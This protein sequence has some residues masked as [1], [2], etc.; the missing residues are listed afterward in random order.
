MAALM[1]VFALDALASNR[2]LIIGVGKHDDAT[3]DLPGIDLDVAMMQDAARNLGFK[4]NEI[5]TLQDDQATLAA[6]TRELRELRKVGGGD[7]VLIYFSGHGSHIPDANGDEEDGQDE[8]LITHDVRIAGD[9]I[10]NALVDDVFAQLLAAIPSRHL[11]LLIDACHSGTA[12]KSFSNLGQRG[13][14]KYFRPSSAISKVA[15]LSPRNLVVTE[16]QSQGHV[17]LSAAM[18]NELAQATSQGSV[19]T[20]GVSHALKALGETRQLTPKELASGVQTFVRE[21]LDEM[22]SRPHTPQLSGDPTRLDANLFFARPAIGPMRERLDA[23]AT[24]LKP[25]KASAERTTYRVGERVKMTFDL[26]ASGYL[27]VVNV[28]AADNA[29]VL[30]PNRH[31]PD[32]QLEKGSVTIPTPQMHFDITVQEPRGKNITYAFLSQKPLDLFQSTVEGRNAKGAIIDILV[33]L[34]ASGYMRTRNLVPV[35]RTGSSNSYAGKV[36]LNVQ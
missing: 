6:I 27:N 16:R 36:V 15:M 29:V 1:L 34:S 14:P 33:P 4:A 22:G 10:E 21:K 30:F 18:D 9:R 23:L 35:G 17:L 2:A 8:V 12:T 3:L 31:H 7:R 19:F 28:N 5:T 26:P 25:L 11:L 13:T 20:L 32:N 24:K